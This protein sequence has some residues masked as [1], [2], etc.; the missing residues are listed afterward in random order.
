MVGHRALVLGRHGPV[1]DGIF[2]AASGHVLTRAQAEAPVARW[3]DF[4]VDIG[5]EDADE[6]RRLGIYGPEKNVD[7][8]AQR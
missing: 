2:A 5:V 1:A 8:T 4:F 7:E 6:A 3:N